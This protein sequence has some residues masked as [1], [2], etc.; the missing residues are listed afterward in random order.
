[1]NEKEELL[2]KIKIENW[3]WILYLF[4]IGFSFYSN[5]LETEYLKTDSCEAK[6]KYR[7][8]LIIIFSVALFVYF[9][10]FEDS[11][12]DVKKQSPCDYPK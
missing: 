11:L 8:S 7:K 2:Q 5:Y 4:L 12:K 10:F 1:M 3:I 9:Y 6:E